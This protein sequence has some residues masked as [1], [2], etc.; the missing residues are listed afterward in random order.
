V[1]EIANIMIDIHARRLVDF[2]FDLDSGAR[3][4]KH[5]MVLNRETRRLTTIK[6]SGCNFGTR[7]PIFP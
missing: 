6:V 5:V 4:L 1:Q 3:D 2:D 7:F